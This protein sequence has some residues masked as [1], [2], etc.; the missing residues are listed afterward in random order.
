MIDRGRSLI[1]I[2]H[3]NFED[4]RITRQLVE[5]GQ[6]MG[7]PVHD[8]LIVTHEGYTSRAERGLMG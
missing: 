1:K 5:A 7:V 4:I 6:L 3:I 8:Q 2:I